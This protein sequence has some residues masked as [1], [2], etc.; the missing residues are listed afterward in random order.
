MVKVLHDQ[1]AGFAPLDPQAASGVGWVVGGASAAVSPD[2]VWTSAPDTL[3][4]HFPSAIPTDGYLYYGHGYGRLAAADQPGQGNA[5]YDLS[6]PPIWAPAVGVKVNV[7]AAPAQADAV[8][9]G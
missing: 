9:L 4:L 6:G 3:V 1:S 7:P 2:G 5:I 8:W